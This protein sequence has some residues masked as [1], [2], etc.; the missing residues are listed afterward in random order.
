MALWLVITWSRSRRRREWAGRTS[1]SY[2]GAL[3]SA[4]A[5]RGG[6]GR[7]MKPSITL[8]IWSMAGDWGSGGLTVVDV[9]DGGGGGGGGER[10]ELWLLLFSEVAVGF[11]KRA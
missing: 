2:L 10:E 1:K 8:L 6:D 5:E 4:R 7:T 9:V 11:S 3:V